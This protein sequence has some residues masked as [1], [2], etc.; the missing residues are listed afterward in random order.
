MANRPSTP[1][2]NV[3]CNTYA[4]D[5]AELNAEKAAVMKMLEKDQKSKKSPP[6]RV[7]ASPKHKEEISKKQQIEANNFKLS[8][9]KNVESKI[10]PLMDKTKVNAQW[11]SMIYFYYFTPN[12]SGRRLFNK[13][14]DILVTFAAVRPPAS[15]LPH[16]VQPPILV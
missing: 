14:N 15:R 8:K 3:I 16:S 7:E 4:Q 9:F 6:P 1:I 5:E 2:K 12:K 11:I 10:K 13:N